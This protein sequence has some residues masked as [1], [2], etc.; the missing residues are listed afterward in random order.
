M[1][2][3]GGRALCVLL[4]ALRVVVDDSGFSHHPTS[5]RMENPSR[6][7]AG[8]ACSVC[9]ASLMKLHLKADSVTPASLSRSCISQGLI[10]GMAPTFTT[11][12]A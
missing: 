10:D 5:N 12:F 2:E 11:S 7:P 1:A 8:C 3:R 4:V 9:S 6:T